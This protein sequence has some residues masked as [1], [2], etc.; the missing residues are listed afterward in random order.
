MELLRKR[1]TNPEK[2]EVFHPSPKPGEEANLVPLL[3]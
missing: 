2:C 1:Q 3:S